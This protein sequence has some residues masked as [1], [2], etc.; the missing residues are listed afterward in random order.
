M[1]LAKRKPRRT[2]PGRVFS[3]FIG[4]THLFGTA[5]LGVYLTGHSEMKLLLVAA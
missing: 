1:H 2:T 3:R 4:S 5:V